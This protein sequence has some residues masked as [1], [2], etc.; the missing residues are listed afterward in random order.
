[1][2]KF[3]KELQD[4]YLLIFCFLVTSIFYYVVQL[5]AILQ[6]AINF[7][8]AFIAIANKRSEQSHLIESVKT[9]ELNTDVISD[10]NVQ[11]ETLN[12][13]E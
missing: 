13:T 6:L 4:R 7:A 2:M 5:D 1:M 11:A 8:V 10:S 9:N 3:L 12:T